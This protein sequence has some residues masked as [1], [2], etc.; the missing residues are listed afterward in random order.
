VVDHAHRLA[1]SDLLAALLRVAEASGAELGVLLVG[2][3][4]WAGGQYLRDTCAVPEPREVH[5][6]S[7]RPQ[8]LQKVGEAGWIRVEAESLAVI[9]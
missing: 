1:G 8:Q 4:G 5:F 6:Q 7:Y 2:R 9:E 3:R